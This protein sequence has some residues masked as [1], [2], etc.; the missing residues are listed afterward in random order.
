MF[1]ALSAN[2]ALGVL[3]WDIKPNNVIL[4]PDGV[5]KLMDFGTS[6]LM[7]LPQTLGPVIGTPDYMA[8]KQLMKMPT[9]PASDIYSAGVLLYEELTG[10]QPLRSWT[11]IERC[12]KTPPPLAAHRPD[13]PPWLDAMV[14]RC[15]QPKA[16]HRFPNAET[17]L[18]SLGSF[19]SVAEYLAPP[20]PAAGIPTVFRPAAQ[21]LTDSPGE[22]NLLAN[23]LNAVLR[24]L[25]GMTEAH[26]PVTPFSVRVASSGEIEIGSHGPVGERD[27]MMVSMPK[28]AAPE[29]MRSQ[30]AGITKADLY[31]VG[32]M[33][34]ELF[35]GRTLF[36]KEF[37][38]TEQCGSGLAWMEWHADAAK[39][40]RPLSVVV[41][42]VPPALTELIASMMENHPAKR[43]AS[44]DAALE[45]LRTYQQRTQPTQQIW[46]I[47]LPPSRRPQAT[48]CWHMAADLAGDAAKRPAL[49][50]SADIPTAPKRGCEKN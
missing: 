46:A 35:L 5:W 2:H 42:G 16:E 20:T 33:I 21:R 12:T 6:R 49:V 4:Q 41:G 14:M 37:A 38:S 8:P 47:R 1:G 15:L 25:K 50:L 27:T 28:Y 40:A 36:R 24:M 26:D 48:K 13:A 17:V 23:L 10:T 19:A 18:M 11:F 31:A 43:M 29:M 32:F 3:H 39:V 7:K 22:V 9:T 44:Y 45:Q 34:Y 30:Q